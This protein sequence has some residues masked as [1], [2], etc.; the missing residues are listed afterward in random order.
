MSKATF[1]QQVGSRPAQGVAG[2]RCGLNPCIYAE[3][4]LLAGAGCVA[5]RFVWRESDLTATGFA[6]AELPPLGLVE[7]VLSLSVYA[8][9]GASLNVPLHNPLSVI[10][11]GDLYVTCA[12]AAFA[13]QKIFAILADGSLHAADAG[14]SVTGGLESNWVVTQGGQAGDLI[15]ISNWE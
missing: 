15:T 1:P 6:P 14:S 5:G 11:R 13:G 7:R 12:N 10:R 4:N 3:S 2:D 9:Q 8:D